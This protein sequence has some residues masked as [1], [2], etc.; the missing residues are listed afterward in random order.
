[1]N[2]IIVSDVPGLAGI[3]ILEYLGAEV[4]PAFR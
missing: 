3:D 2:Y 4:L 1:M